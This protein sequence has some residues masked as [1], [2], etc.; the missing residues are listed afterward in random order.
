MLTVLARLTGIL[1][2]KIGNGKLY[3]YNNRFNLRYKQHTV[4]D[5]RNQCLALKPFFRNIF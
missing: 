5:P 4:L 1:K 3:I 2:G